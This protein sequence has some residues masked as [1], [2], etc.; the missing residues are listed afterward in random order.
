MALKP[1]DVPII[2]NNRNRLTT[3]QMMINWLE[4]IGFSR[5]IILDNDSTYP[6]LLDF[7]RKTSHQVVKLRANIGYLALWESELFDR[8]RT[9]HY[10]YSDSDV[11]PTETCPTNI[12]ELFEYGL[13]RYS[14][15]NKVGFSLKIDD[16][17]H[18]C[19]ARDQII[20]HENQFWAKP[21][22]AQFYEAH[23]DTTF[24]LYRPFAR[25]GWWEPAL[26]TSS[27]YSARHLPWYVN[28]NCLTEEELYY[29]T[30]VSPLSSYWTSKV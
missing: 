15:F 18:H 16:I 9:A 19:Q 8:I 20:S 21:L 2:I 29:K 3:L 7:Y 6:P 24:A 12:L 27:P 1:C 10:I 14:Q 30:H 23:I 26:R 22:D 28:S 25:G 13:E 11:V 4:P 5:I 17:P